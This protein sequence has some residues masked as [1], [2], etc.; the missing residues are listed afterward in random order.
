L[1]G[2]EITMPEPGR[3]IIKEPD[4][5]INL[6]GRS[7]DDYFITAGNYSRIKSVLDS[8]QKKVMLPE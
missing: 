1:L 5:F 7:L 4:N 3:K 6:I 8:S 2:Y